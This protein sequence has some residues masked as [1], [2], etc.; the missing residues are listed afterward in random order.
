MKLTI[1]VRPDTARALREGTTD[2]G[3]TA[4]RDLAGELGAT[5]EPVHPGSLEPGL[6]DAFALDVSDPA[7]AARMSERL[8]ALECVDAAY[9]KP[10]DE[11]PAP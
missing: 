2:P 5:L 3:A 9:V 8:R 10:A 1:H 4:L 11:P 6:A 7:V